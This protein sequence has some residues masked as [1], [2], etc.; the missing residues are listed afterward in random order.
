V[1][2]TRLGAIPGFIEYGING[3]LVTL[4]NV[5]ELNNLKK[6]IRLSPNKEK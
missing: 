6:L 3:Y 2:S 1:I 4:G 5:A